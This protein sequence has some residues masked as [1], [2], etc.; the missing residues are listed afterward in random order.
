[1]VSPLD[2]RA[3]S[4]VR[5]ISGGREHRHGWAAI[6]RLKDKPDRLA[7]AERVEVAIDDVGHYCRPFRQ[8]HIGDRVGHRRAPHDAV[9]ID[10][11]AARGFLPFDLVAKAERAVRPRIEMRL[12]ASGAF[13]VEE[14]ALPGRFPEMLGFGVDRRRGDLAL[15]WLSLLL[16]LGHGAHSLS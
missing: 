14:L 13:L 6:A 1:M 12:A 9:G 16:C 15:L 3:I 10:R 4:Y 5:R 8:R 11:A 7:D 2:P